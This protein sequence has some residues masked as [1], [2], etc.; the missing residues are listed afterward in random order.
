MVTLAG[1]VQV[2]CTC[3]CNTEQLREKQGDD[4]TKPCPEEDLLAVRVG[5]LVDSVVGSIRSPSGCEAIDDS[6]ER[7]HTAKLRCT[8]APRYVDEIAAVSKDTQDDEKDNGSWD[9]RPEFVRVYDL[10]PEKCNEESAERDDQD[11]S[12]AGHRGVD[13]VDEL[14][15]N[16]GVDRGP[17]DTSKNVENG[18]YSMLGQICPHPTVK[19]MEPTELHAPPTEP[20]TGQNHL[21]QAEFGAQGREITD[22]RDTDEV[23]EEHDKH[24]VCRT[25]E[26]H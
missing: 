23:E 13:C 4:Q 15:S 18:D 8:N 14:S 17:A 6:A 5:W 21:A 16:D 10:V 25:Q 2:H 7:E 11:T 22:R 9:P 1:I 24:G 12:K 3:D 20:E 26:P 19:L